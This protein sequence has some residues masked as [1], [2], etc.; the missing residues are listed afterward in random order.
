MSHV[1][2]F[3]C[4]FLA[5]IT[6]G[7]MSSFTDVRNHLSKHEEAKKVLSRMMMIEQNP[8]TTQSELDEM[9]DPVYELV[10]SIHQYSCNMH[11]T[12]YK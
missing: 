5:I 2:L 8:F 6:L 10:R 7:W 12:L 9:Y 1:Y 3:Y 11:Y 4:F